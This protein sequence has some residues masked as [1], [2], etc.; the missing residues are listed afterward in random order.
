[1]THLFLDSERRL[2]NGW[3]MVVFLA[4]VALTAIAYRPVSR[5][6]KG[7]G[8]T[9]LWLEPAPFL[10]C[11][12]ATWAAT[13]LRR[14]P[15]SSVGFRLGPAWAKQAA[16]G[17]LAGMG[18][19]TLAVV[20]IWATGG[21]SFELDPARSVGGLL[22]GLY[23]FL[24][25]ALLEETLYRGFL[26][27]RFVAGAGVVI[28]QVAMGLLFAVAHWGNP[29]M[30][31]AAKIW[32]TV[33]TALGAMVLGLAFLRTRSLAL[34]IGL[35]LGWNWAQGSLFGFGVSGIGQAGWLRPVFH[36][37][38]EW[39]TG[40]SF[41]PEASAFAVVVDLASIA[42]LWRWRG[43]AATASP[44]RGDAGTAGPLERPAELG[45]EVA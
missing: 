34:P 35:H 12:F 29:G 27:Q 41:G 36:G 13:R 17:T 2:R 8:A 22:V 10:F 37:K 28:A 19:L 3:W 44:E 11:L 24:F 16:L 39:L 26:F 31:G 7:L 1:V 18:T 30:T 15:L 32:A 42:L 6:L 4:L 20:M 21:V 5:G 23:V 33:D 45:L 43:T 40:G 38:A 9:E 14:E 25:V